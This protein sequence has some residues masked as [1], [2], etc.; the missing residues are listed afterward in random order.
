MNRCDRVRFVIA[1]GAL[2]VG[3]AIWLCVVAW[4]SAP[5]I[6]WQ[7]SIGSGPM[8]TVHRAVVVGSV[9]ARDT[10]VV[11]LRLVNS[12]R[13]HVRL[14]RSYTTCGCLAVTRAPDKQVLPPGAATTLEVTV[15][16]LGYRAGAFSQNLFVQLECD[17]RSWTDSVVVQGTVT[18]GLSFTAT[19]LDFGTVPAGEGGVGRLAFVSSDDGWTVTAVRWLFDDAHVEP[20]AFHVEGPSH[21]RGEVRILWPAPSTGGTHERDVLVETTHPD[22]PRFVIRGRLAVVGGVTVVPPRITLGRVRRGTPSSW[23]RVRI[24]CEGLIVR[25]VRAE[26]ADGARFLE[27][28]VRSTEDRSS[29]MDVRYTGAPSE[30]TNVNGTVTLESEGRTIVVPFRA[31][32]LSGTP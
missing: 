16:V 18:V 19:E 28:Q 24:D 8:V 17:G 4:H 31:V 5:D 7:A 14:V 13:A 21:G 9:S 3:L 12:G 30:L 25:A 27:V 10:V 22:V 15:K 26:R 29:T 20:P 11:K 32:V 6:V 23:F 2:I 1:A